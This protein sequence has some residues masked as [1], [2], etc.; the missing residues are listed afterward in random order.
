MIRT[1]SPRQAAIPSVAA[2]QTL[3]HKIVE[4]LP[5]TTSNII[6]VPPVRGNYEMFIRSVEFLYANNVIDED[7]IIDHAVII[8][9]AP[10]FNPNEGEDQRRLLYSSYLSKKR[11][12]GPFLLFRMMMNMRGQLD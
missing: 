6:V 10:F 11:I 7:D 8:F 5:P 3:A 1:Q 4:V 12:L 9:M 2:P